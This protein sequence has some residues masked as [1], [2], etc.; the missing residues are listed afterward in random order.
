MLHDPSK[1]ARFIGILALLTPLASACRRPAEAGREPP[2][3]SATAHSAELYA[4]RP[5]PTGE[6][7]TVPVPNDRDVLVVLG[8]TKRPIVYIH[9]MCAEARPDLDAWATAVNHYGT[10]I[11]LE[12]DVICPNGNR[13]TSWSPD[14]AALDARID[15][16]IAAVR[17]A[18][19]V[20][21]VPSEV[22][23]IGESLGAS[24]A[25]SLASRFP[26]K[27]TRLVVVGGPET[28]SSKELASTKA[29]ALLAGE[30]ESQEK[31]RQGALRLVSAGLSARFWELPA[32]THGSYGPE[33]ARVMAEAVA[34][35]TTAP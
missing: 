17:D 19:H 16:A 5:A 15:A 13:G 7:E 25:L 20:A 28:P 11:A 8:E 9:G 35:A 29:V 23:V 12:G 21:L 31:M 10:I 1:R 24:R 22:L 32:A 26:S 27:Y 33:G 4:P 30:N 2:A 14:A 34:F 6:I 3:S 18:R